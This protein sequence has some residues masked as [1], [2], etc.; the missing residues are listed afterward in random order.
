VAGWPGGRVVRKDEVE[1]VIRL[2]QERDDAERELISLYK[3][4]GTTLDL[5]KL[6]EV[7]KPK[8]LGVEQDRLVPRPAR[9]AAGT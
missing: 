5:R 4:G 3:A 9:D 7:L 1:E 2:S 6:T 8:G